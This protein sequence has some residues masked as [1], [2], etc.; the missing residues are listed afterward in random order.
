MHKTTDFVDLRVGDERPVLGAHHPLSVVA[1]SGVVALAGALAG[2]GDQE[3]ERSLQ[4]AQVAMNPSVAPI[5]DD[6]EMQIYEVKA[7]VQF[8]ILAPDPLT[9]ESLQGRDIPPYPRAP[10]VTNTDVR[11]QLTWTLSNLDA[12]E[13]VVEVLI[14]PWNEFGRYWPGLQVTDAENEEY[15]PNLSGIDKYYIIPGRDAGDA[16]RIH[17]TYTFDDMDEMAIDFATV[18][19]MIAY[20]PMI[21]GG[22]GAGEYEDPTVTYTNHAFEVRNRSFKDPLVKPYIPAVI[23]GLTGIDFGLRSY[24]PATI[25]IEVAVEVVDQGNGRV[26]ERGSDDPLLEA[27]AEARR[28][29]SAALARAA[30]LPPR[31]QPLPLPLPRPTPLPSRARAQP[32]SMDRDCV[33]A[34]GRLARRARPW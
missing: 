6:G 8:P 29:S 21:P 15:M 34:L 23:P 13:R 16:S 31:R 2:C 12:E 10:W 5:Y 24:T 7:Q 25:A 17:G 28:R 20:P 22:D 27:P 18:M 4:P 33:A 3:V 9:M 26:R 19:N 1:L 32:D 11:V 14:D 30:P